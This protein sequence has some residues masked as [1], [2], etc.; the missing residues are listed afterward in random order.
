MKHNENNDGMISV[1]VNICTRVVT[2]IFIMITIFRKV[3]S[4]SG[5]LVMGLKDIW[6]V[7]LIGIVS[8]LAFV[9]FIKKKK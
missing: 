3:F 8:G 6:G 2:M 9:I 4:S 1:M 7:L 5:E